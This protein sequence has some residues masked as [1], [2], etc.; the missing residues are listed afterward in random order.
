MERSKKGHSLHLGL[1]AVNPAHY[2]GWSGELAACEADADDMQVI[3]SSS[4]FARSAVLKTRDATRAHV[5]S[6]IEKAAADLRP[7]DL[8]F[9]S[10]SGHGGQIPDRNGDEDDYADE[11]WCLYDGELID[12][13]LYG[14]WQKFQAGV[15]VVV[16][17]DS[18]H[19][20]SVTRMMPRLGLTAARRE[21]PADAT[22]EAPR[23]RAMPIFAATRTYQQNKKFY[24]D[25]QAK[26][27][28]ERGEIRATV[29]LISGCHD[30]QL[31]AD[32]TFNGLF[33]ATL[34]RV[35]RGGGFRRNYAAFHKAIV[36]RMPPDQTP[37]H[38]VIGRPSPEFDA[39]RPFAI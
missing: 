36:Q 33:T 13:E 19:S 21:A 16:L 35:W 24:D 29:R 7:G 9:L 11:T 39:E 14:L 38:S 8:F 31:S 23:Y 22:E 15:R 34:L 5:I 37:Q 12:D 30:N 10:Y 2:A 20:G 18:C 27:S 17:S 4:E 3:A 26:V 28:G 6:E 32:G 1:N 25:L